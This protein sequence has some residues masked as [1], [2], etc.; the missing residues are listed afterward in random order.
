MICDVCHTNE[1][2]GMALENGTICLLY[3]SACKP[4]PR[5]IGLGVPCEICRY[6]EAVVIWKAGKKYCQSCRDR[7]NCTNRSHVYA[8]AA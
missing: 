2:T 1:A 4:K 8:G 6:N 3:C 5:Y 7:E